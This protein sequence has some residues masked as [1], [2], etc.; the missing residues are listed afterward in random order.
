VVLGI[1][2]LLKSKVAISE[3]IEVGGGGKNRRRKKYIFS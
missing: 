3:N 1:G 2:P